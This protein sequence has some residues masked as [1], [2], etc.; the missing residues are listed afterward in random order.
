MH[1][2][3]LSKFAALTAQDGTSEEEFLAIIETD[4]FKIAY[5]Q[6]LDG[7][8]ERLANGRSGVTKVERTIDHTGRPFADKD[9]KYVD[10]RCPCGINAKI[11]QGRVR[12][13]KKDTVS[14]RQ[15]TIAEAAPEAP[16]AGP[17]AGEDF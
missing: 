4:A 10:Y 2:K 3:L 5:R 13:P 8:A 14:P 7:R 12:E 11:R 15:T 9:G 17:S 6:V 1:E 16:A